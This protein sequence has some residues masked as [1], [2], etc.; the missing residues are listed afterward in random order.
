MLFHSS[1]NLR[2]LIIAVFFLCF[3]FFLYFYFSSFFFSFFCFFLFFLFFLY[4][5]FLS[6]FFVFSFF[7]FFL[8][9]F[10]TNKEK[11]RPPK[12]GRETPQTTGEEGVGR[13]PPPL[14]PPCPRPLLL[15]PP[16]SP[17]SP[18]NKGGETAKQPGGDTLQGEAKND[19]VMSPNQQ[20]RRVATKK[21]RG[22]FPPWFSTCVMPRAAQSRI[23]EL[24]E[25]R[26][27]TC[28]SSRRLSI[29]RLNMVSGKAGASLLV[30]NKTLLRNEH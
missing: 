9:F 10:P 22:W 29:E 16:P 21:E 26:A 13:K 24:Y 1:Q 4:F 5:L 18:S 28:S 14:P 2:L 7:L 11:G 25:N 23:K 6:F 15:P 20:G 19:E 8:F 12:E 17:S 3:S 27:G 30:S